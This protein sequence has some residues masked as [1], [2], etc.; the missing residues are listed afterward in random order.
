MTLCI[1]LDRNINV[2][3]SVDVSVLVYACTVQPETPPPPPSMICPIKP[4]FPWP[5]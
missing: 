1:S 3:L 5:S 4:G 2:F